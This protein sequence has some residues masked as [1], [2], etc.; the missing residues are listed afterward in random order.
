MRDEKPDPVAH[1]QHALEAVDL[2]GRRKR[3]LQ[4]NRRQHAQAQHAVGGDRIAEP[5]APR[6]PLGVIVRHLVGR[7]VGP[8]VERADRDLTRPAW[9]RNDADGDGRQPGHAQNRGGRDS[10]ATAKQRSG[11]PRRDEGPGGR[12]NSPRDAQGIASIWTGKDDRRPVPVGPPQRFSVPDRPKAAWVEW[13]ALRQE[14][15]ASKP[16]RRRPAFLV[17]VLAVSLIA[18][19]L[20]PA[21]AFANFFTPK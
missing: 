1:R 12:S 20:L 3:P 11:D 5:R 6:E 15:T 17:A 18:T 16:S 2:L 14:V 7:D 8:H 4:P 10:H 21:H 19:L 9:A 13:P